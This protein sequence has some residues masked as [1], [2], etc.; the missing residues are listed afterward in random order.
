MRTRKCQE[1]EWYWRFF[2]ISFL[3]NNIENYF[4]LNFALKKYHK[5]SLS[6][7]ENMIP[8]E[9]DVYVTLI[10]EWI[11]EEKIKNAKR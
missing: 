4:R 2:L 10:R 11:E 6:E 1:V 7:I 8:W 5:F 9:R 3:Y